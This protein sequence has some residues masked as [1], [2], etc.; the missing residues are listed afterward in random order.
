ML[1]HLRTG[2]RQFV[3]RLGAITGSLGEPDPPLARLLAGAGDGATELAAEAGH[4]GTDARGPDRAVGVRAFTGFALRPDRIES[5]TVPTSR[6][7][8]SEVVREGTAHPSH[9]RPA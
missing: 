9:G 2:D 1:H 3:A 7:A 4:L 6:D 8:A 5:R